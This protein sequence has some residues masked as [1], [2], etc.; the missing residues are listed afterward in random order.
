MRLAI[1]TS[2]SIG[3]A[4]VDG[5][6]VLHTAS[7]YAPRHHAERLAVMV[8]DALDRTGTSAHAIQQVVVGTGPGPFTGLRVGVVTA[9]TLG[10]AWSVPVLG[11]CSLDALGAAHGGDVT[12]VTDARRKEV[13]WARYRAGL[14]IE[15]PQVGPASSV[16]T[17]GTVVGRGALLYEE[18]FG[19]ALDPAEH[20]RDV[21]AAWLALIVE[22]A[23]DNTPEDYPTAP[24]Y[25]RRPDVH[26]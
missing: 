18:V 10:E 3:V 14:R 4:L 12:V 1:D 15:D 16:P 24:Q 19:A 21:D 23:G 5:D 25:L 22:A 6:R 11:V 13:Y 2:G 17:G 20:L 26:H 8:R 7:D 9:R